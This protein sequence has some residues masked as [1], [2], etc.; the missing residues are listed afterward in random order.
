LETSGCLFG[1]N[2]DW[3]PAS[4]ARVHLIRKLESVER[5]IDIRSTEHF[6]ELVA[7][8]SSASGRPYQVRCGN[9]SPQDSREWLLRQLG[10][11]RNPR[12]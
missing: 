4:E 12:D 7:V 1:R 2:G 9:A 3:H 6:I 5:R 11:V 8:R 10:S